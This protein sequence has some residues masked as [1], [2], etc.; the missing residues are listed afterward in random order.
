MAIDVR[1]SLFFLSLGP[2]ARH[3]PHSRLSCLPDHH[4]ME[5]LDGA[6]DA[7]ASPRLPASLAH[8]HPFLPRLAAAIVAK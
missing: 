2:C 5:C 6:C 4:P 7:V 8:V 1:L 3:S